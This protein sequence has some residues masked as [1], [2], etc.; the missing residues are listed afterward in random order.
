MTWYETIP[1]FVHAEPKEVILDFPAADESI[2]ILA[3]AIDRWIAALE[4]WLETEHHF[5]GF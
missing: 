3:E 5:S 4:N 1:A 2:K